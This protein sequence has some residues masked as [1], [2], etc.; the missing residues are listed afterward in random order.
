MQPFGQPNRPPPPSPYNPP[1]RPAM[2]YPVSSV[3]SSPAMSVASPPQ[4]RPPFSAPM[5]TPVLTP[6][7]PPLM[8]HA[9][10]M[11]PAS[12]GVPAYTNAPPLGPPPGS[13][14]Q[15]PP[16]AH[17]ASNPL[18]SNPMAPP[19]YRPKTSYQPT[20]HDSPKQQQQQQQQHGH[21]PSQSTLQPPNA[22]GIS[23]SASQSTLQRPPLAQVPSS[24]SFDAD[25]RP[26]ELLPV[27]DDD[28]DDD[29][30][31]I[32]SAPKTPS[33]S[34]LT[35]HAQSPKTPQ[36]PSLSPALSYLSVATTSTITSTIT[37]TLAQP[38][39]QSSPNSS[40]SRPSAA[41]VF[42]NSTLSTP[43]TSLSSAEQKKPDPFQPFVPPA[44]GGSY[45][46][47]SSYQ[48]TKPPKATPKESPKPAPS[49]L[50]SH[51][52]IKVEVVDGSFHRPPSLNSGVPVDTSIKVPISSEPSAVPRPPI[53]SQQS[54]SGQ[55][56]SSLPPAPPVLSTPQLQSNTDNQQQQQSSGRPA[57]QL[58]SE[59]SQESISFDSLEQFVHNISASSVDRTPTPPPKSTQMAQHSTTVTSDQKRYTLT[60]APLR[61]SQ[62]QAARPAVAPLGL[63]AKRPVSQPPSTFGASM[64]PGEH[65]QQQ[66][67]Q[68]Q[69][70]IPPQSNQPS[71]NGPGVAPHPGPGGPI[72]PTPTNRP[73]MQ[74]QQQPT[75]PFGEK[76]LNFLDPGYMNNQISSMAASHDN[77]P[78][79]L[80][81]PMV[82]RNKTLRRAADLT[83]TGMA[84][85]QPANA[86][87]GN[88]SNVNTSLPPQGVQGPAPPQPGPMVPQFN[89]TP[90]ELYPYLL[91]I[92]LLAQALEA[93]PPT[94][95]AP[96]PVGTDK[97]THKDLIK[98]VRSKVKE[99]LSNKDRTPMFQD[100]VVRQALSHM[101]PKQFKES[102][103]VEGLLVTFTIEMSRIQQA[104]GMPPANRFDQIAIMDK[105]VREAIRQDP[106]PG[107]EGILQRLDKQAKPVAAKPL[108]TAQA[109]KLLKVVKDL[110]RLQDSTRQQRM[111][112][113]KRTSTKQNALD[114]L[115]KV[116][117]NLELD[118]FPYPGK[119]DYYDQGHHIAFK[120]RERSAVTGL[121]R[122]LASSMNGP[123]GPDANSRVYHPSEFVFIP[124]N[125]KE[126]YRLLLNMCVDHALI[127][128]SDKEPVANL[129]SA[130]AK[131]LLKECGIRW[132]LTSSWR[133]I[134]YMEVIKE[135]YREGKIPIGSL[136]EFMQTKPYKDSDIPQWHIT[137]ANMLSDFY[138]SLNYM[139]FDNIN[140]DIRDF[141]KVSLAYFSSMLSILNKVHEQDVFKRMNINLT[142]FIEDIKETI[143][144]EAVKRFQT[145]DDEIQKEGFENETVPLTKT[146]VFIVSEHGKLKKRFPEKLFPDVDV[147]G[148]VIGNYLGNF[149]PLMQN[150]ANMDARK[151]P[152][153]DVFPLYQLCRELLS[154]FE[155]YA[156]S[157][158]AHF[159]LET[160]FRPYVLKYIDVLDSTITD[161]VTSA[162]AQDTFE[163]VSMGAGHSSSASDLF[164]FFYEPLSW[165]KGLNWPN[166]YQRAVFISKLAKVFCRAVDLYAQYIESMFI[167]CLPSNVTT[168]AHTEVMS[169]AE[170]FSM[171]LRSESA[172]KKAA[173]FTFSPRMCIL[174]N[175]IEAVRQ[176]LDE[177]YRN[178][179]VDEIA[180]ILQ[181]HAPEQT[182]DPNDPKMFEIVFVGAERLRPMDSNEASDPYIIMSHED[183]E[184]FRSKTVYANL[185]PRWNETYNVTLTKEIKYLIVINDEDKVH[186]DRLCAWQYLYI[187]PLDYEDYMPHD[188]WLDLAQIGRL[189]LRIT[190]KGE[191][192]DLQF[193]FGRTFRS[194]K[195]KESD[196]S[197]MIVDAMLPAV[198]SC[199]NERVLFQNFRSKS[200]LSF[201]NA[202][203]TSAKV[204]QVSDEE[205]DKALYPLFDYLEAALPVLYD[206]LSSDNMTLVISK[207]WKEMLNMIESLLMPP[208]STTCST[209]TPLTEVESHV[210]FKVVEFI[211]LYLNGGDAGDGFSLKILETA[212]YRDFVTLHLIYD[213]PA[214]DLMRDYNDIIKA[215]AQPRL[216]RQ[217]SNG[218]ADGGGGGRYQPVKK[219][220]YK[221][222]PE[223]ILRVLRMRQSPEVEDFLE[224]AIDTQSK[225]REARAQTKREQM[226]YQRK[227]MLGQV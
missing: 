105:L 40:G 160:W 145:K 185:N 2:S 217:Q 43:P 152:M 44:G 99:I 71:S 165:V 124:P 128:F 123:A 176:R 166:E 39:P 64:P 157:Q 161:W 193:Y 127:S 59:G 200:I 120:N 61:D 14:V 197:G 35:P 57:H 94:A 7:P 104:K 221:P 184:V 8:H 216:G 226:A 168:A 199:L 67:Q 51:D 155:Q 118:S 117:V 213:L 222:N 129:L 224:K 158:G 31:S 98:A 130:P 5:A 187:D 91:R 36:P 132:R 147:V 56:T 77:S 101:E 37:T 180:D 100:P 82:R 11:P 58:L 141:E 182:I 204:T 93:P 139:M 142:P 69:P 163:E 174:M 169:L 68:Q 10:S 188:V 3:V 218:P 205:C 203:S 192:E 122:A 138:G 148:I 27:D 4:S 211:K 196:L 25:D 167:A 210:V 186:K 65:T 18:T 55:S 154:L 23:P 177:L 6:Q 89:V 212:K 220:F 50:H 38:H 90:D 113:L 29:A 13:S 92:I 219:D 172:E 170:R 146:A 103:N 131:S 114:D 173:E 32:H 47:K 153:D 19:V 111:N 149:V 190:M 227:V 144:V 33:L 102:S 171:A 109:D 195:R 126:Y 198:Q 95:P 48:P 53:L 178:M 22:T 73:L 207:L 21:S 191:R 74:Q 41:S 45:Q 86:G 209:R 159:S 125:P 194:L 79:Q 135:R 88:D 15:P 215:A 175:N 151:L 17:G 201:F 107:H 143:L 97:E 119:E 24:A 70:K 156:P 112:D 106:F 42:T 1:T 223:S 87:P 115:K 108:A 136:L 62:D 63:T 121:I 164:Q 133:D 202:S 83:G 9:P 189:Q 34:S 30:H 137:E 206:Y 80:A 162:I 54:H 183:K 208:L 49:S 78:A 150:M 214:E 134:L 26:T 225:A 85:H 76:A 96:I 60:D 20:K 72:V 81:P 66:Q 12:T 52:T 116:L 28:D 16:P 110:F 46:P 140:H 84:P 179:E 75:T 181:E